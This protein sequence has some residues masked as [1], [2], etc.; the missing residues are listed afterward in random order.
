M[1]TTKQEKNNL[2]MSQMFAI[3]ENSILSPIGKC[4]CLQ[5]S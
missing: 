3:N 5:S 2:N 1:M 4:C